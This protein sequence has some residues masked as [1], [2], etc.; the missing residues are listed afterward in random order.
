MK[1]NRK[2]NAPPSGNEIDYTHIN[3]C[4][5]LTES[6]SETGALWEMFK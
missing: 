6:R 1:N 4:R 3:D 2:Q 5:S